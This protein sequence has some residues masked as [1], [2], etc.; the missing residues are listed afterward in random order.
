M[1]HSQTRG[2]R[3][4]WQG[5][6][7]PRVVVA[8]VRYDDQ[9]NN[10]HNTFAVTGTVYGRHGS[11]RDGGTRTKDGGMLF[12]ESCGCVHDDIA[13]HIPELAGLIKW[14]L[15][16]SNEPWGYVDNT[17]YH[18]GDRDCW[19]LKAGEFRQHTSRGPTQ[20]GGTPGVN[21]WVLEVPSRTQ[22]DVYA[23][24]CPSPVLIEWKPCGKT[25]DGKKREL[26]LA[27]SSAVWPE[28][29]DA[30]LVQEPDALRAALSARLPALM[31]DFRTAI[32]SLGFT[33]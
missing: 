25:G 1:A 29:T 32:E 7:G 24:T 16:S 33:Y 4:E 22:R 21:N 9:C 26:D 2:F 28:A 23:D 10:G 15:C 27:R 31:A 19:G 17:V 18:A 6:D 5:D 13:A 20:N 30:E 11:K 14:H 12:V 3:A 8:S